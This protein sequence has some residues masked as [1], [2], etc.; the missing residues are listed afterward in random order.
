ML[1]LTDKKYL[2]KHC[3]SQPTVKP[4]LS[5]LSKKDHKLAFKMDYRLMQ[6]NILQNAAREH[7]AIHLTFTKLPFVICFVFFEWF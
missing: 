6:V 1:K 7:S 5:D 4:V 2:K 3:L